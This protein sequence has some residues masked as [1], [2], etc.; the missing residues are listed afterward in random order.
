MKHPKYKYEVYV[1]KNK[2]NKILGLFVFRIIHFKSSSVIKLVDY[3]GKDKDFPTIN[4]LAQ[5]L[6]DKNKSEYIIFYCYGL[7][8][9]YITQSGF[10]NINEKKIIEPHYFEPFVNKNIFIHCG[11]IKKNSISKIRIFLGDGDG[12]RPRI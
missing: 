6:L 2:N 8:K 5:Y 9:K 12:D 7:A 10:V 11:Y 3:V 1:T 4:S